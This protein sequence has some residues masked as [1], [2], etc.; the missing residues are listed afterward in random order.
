MNWKPDAQAWMAYIKMEMRYQEHERAR[1][2]FERCL[3][4]FHSGVS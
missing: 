3:S 1:Q 2:I 4:L